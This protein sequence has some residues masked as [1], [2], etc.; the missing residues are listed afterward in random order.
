MWK[1]AWLGRRLRSAALVIC[2]CA[3]GVGVGAPSAHAQLITLARRVNLNVLVLSAGDVGTEMI[4]AGL[5]EGAVPF[6]EIDLRAAG[7]QQITDAFLAD[8]ASLFVKRGKFQALVLPN[9]AP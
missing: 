2:V 9:E 5:R 1:F 3:L 8:S 4:K 6:T 7:R